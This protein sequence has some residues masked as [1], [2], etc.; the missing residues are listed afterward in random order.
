MSRYTDESSGWPPPGSDVHVVS[1]GT[2]HGKK[3]RR[4]WPWV[5]L[6]AVI[7]LCGLGMV[8]GLDSVITD[9]SKD[10]RAGTP[11]IAPP[12]S[13]LP[14]G[15]ITEG[16]WEVGG[17]DGPVPGEYQVTAPV[18]EEPLCYWQVSEDDAGRDIISNDNPS[19]GRP[20]VTL[21]KGQW[22]R[23]EGCGSWK[24]VTQK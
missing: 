9:A 5:A 4:I 15:M 12:P 2:V 3:K 18:K 22:F 7:V 1:G 10:M 11:V 14:D 23:T 20:Q 21:K 16:V 17:L 13:A 6:A 8:V 24:L 19:G